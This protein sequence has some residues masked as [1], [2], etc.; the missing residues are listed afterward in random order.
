MLAGIDGATFDRVQMAL[1][2]G[3]IGGNVCWLDID[4]AGPHY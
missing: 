4:D 3:S 2:V 1:Q